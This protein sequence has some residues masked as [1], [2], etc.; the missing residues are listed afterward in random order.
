[1]KHQKKSTS[2][3]L[4]STKRPS[5][6]SKGGGVP[7]AS[8]EGGTSKF[9][10]LFSDRAKGFLI[11]LNFRNA[12]P[13]PPVGP[14]FVGLGLDGEINDKWTR[15]KPNNA[16][17]KL[18][19]WELH[20]ELDLGV[21]IA[22]SAM[23]YEGCY[24]D[25]KKK[26]KN[27]GEV[28]RALHPKDA[29]ILNW[30]GSLGDSVLEQLQGRRERARAHA[31]RSSKGILTPSSVNKNKKQEFSRVL[32]E[33]KPSFMQKTTLITNDQ[34][35]SVHS[36]KS[37]AQNKAEAA[38]EIRKKLEETKRLHTG[39][40]AVE[41]SFVV[42]RSSGDNSGGKS[43]GP[44]SSVRK[45][46]RKRNVHAL[47][48]IPLLP[49]AKTWGHS[50]QHVVIDSLPTSMPTNPHR[51]RLDKNG[52]A[53][54]T[55]VTSKM[56]EKAF[57]TDVSRSQE[58]VRMACNLLLPSL[59]K[60]IEANG[61][62]KDILYN[63]S[64]SYDLDVLPLKEEGSPCTNFLF[65]IDEGKGKATYHPVTSKVQLST[66]RRPSNTDSNRKLL[67]R[68]VGRREMGTEDVKEM[69]EVMAEV[70][71]DYA[72]EDEEEGSVEKEVNKD[73]DETMGNKS[74]PPFGDYDD[75]TDDSDDEF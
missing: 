18:Y 65:T 68:Y 63:V 69:E 46:P 57:V 29:S 61:E 62:N 37:L 20:S 35:K 27:G 53:E 32:R 70:D 11:D 55:S 26:Q 45:H 6:S 71:K 60:E 40:D 34:S 4:K 17:D 73:G 42:C 41:R 12:P 50:F 8:G 14:C 5:S 38:K 2:N 36:F 75:D 39:I 21:P 51:I 33:D 13:R 10:S 74:K 24:V 59:N 9:Q 66:G 16:I 44:S 25:P 30:K 49:D 54:T 58:S 43:R 22:P 56:L 15:F 7:S 52:N 31:L 47:Y 1:V 3:E 64:L 23:D 67:T 19:T 48:E 28:S 72:V